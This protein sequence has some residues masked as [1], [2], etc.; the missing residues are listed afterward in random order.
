MP[1]ISNTVINKSTINKLLVADKHV[2][3]SF[4]TEGGKACIEPVKKKIIPLCNGNLRKQS[5]PGVVYYY[6]YSAV[7][8]IRSMAG[9][10]ITWW[11]HLLCL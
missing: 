6:Y 9:V 4:M 7:I 3:G 2:C 11:G 1:S 5:S 10:R 8:I